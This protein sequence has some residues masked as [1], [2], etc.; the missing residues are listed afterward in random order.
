MCSKEVNHISML[1]IKF[2][3]L[4][5]C[6]A[7]SINPNAFGDCS[8]PLYRTGIIWENSRSTIAMQISIRVVDLAPARLRCLAEALRQRYQD[9]DRINVII[10]SSQSA[11]KHC[12]PSPYGDGPRLQD[13]DRAEFCINQMHA[14]YSFDATKEEE[15]VEIMPV[16]GSI[17][18]GTWGTRIDLPETNATQCGLQIEGRCLLVLRD[19]NY[20]QD[21]LKE[22]ASG[23]VT[24][25]GT[26]GKTGT[27]NGIHGVGPSTNPSTAYDLL[28]HQ[29]VQN[30]KT[31]RFE[32]S[33]RRDRIRITYRY[34]IDPSLRPG[35]TDVQFALPH[36]VVIRT[37]PSTS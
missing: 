34:I 19:L 30:L 35:G 20:P 10:F 24:L 3:L 8:A 9:R 22:K 2:F 1:R 12:N 15:Y 16:R 4:T 32:S 28:A 26:I 33:S 13:T 23:S 36:E 37:G 5:A 18:G 6:T 14:M 21:V 25:E 11:A 7:L 31:W 29:A 27:V 17:D